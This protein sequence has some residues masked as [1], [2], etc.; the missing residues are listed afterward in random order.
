[1]CLC[2]YVFVYECL[3]TGHG[4]KKE[5]PYRRKESL[6]IEVVVLLWK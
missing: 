2:V 1:M 6:T 5:A 4:L 3:S